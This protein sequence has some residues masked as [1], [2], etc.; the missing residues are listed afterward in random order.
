MWCCST[1]ITTSELC[2]RMS[3]PMFLF[4]NFVLFEFFSF[5]KWIVWVL[6]SVDTDS[7]GDAPREPGAYH[8][9]AVMLDK[10][11]AMT[12]YLWEVESPYPSKPTFQPCTFFMGTVWRRFVFL[13]LPPSLGA[14]LSIGEVAEGFPGLCGSPWREGI[15]V[16]SH[17]LLLAAR[18]LHFLT[19]VGCLWH[20]LWKLNWHDGGLCV[21]DNKC[22]SFILQVLFGFMILK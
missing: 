14:V 7:A 22:T 17:L 3:L 4:F 5:V 21:T 11:M 12:N 18:F 19:C 16:R 20:L 15:L 8:T 1:L 10:R 2:W 6:D 13:F 9:W